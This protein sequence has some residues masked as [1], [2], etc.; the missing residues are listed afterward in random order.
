[1]RLVW[2]R[3]G[4]HTPK[5]HLVFQRLGW[6]FS[7]KKRNYQKSFIGKNKLSLKCPNLEGFLLTP[8]DEKVMYIWTWTEINS[9]EYMIS[10]CVLI[11]ERNSYIYIY[12][13]ISSWGICGPPGSRLPGLISKVITWQWRSTSHTGKWAQRIYGHLNCSSLKVN[14]DFS[15]ILRHVFNDPSPAGDGTFWFL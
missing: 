1:M 11:K 8:L 4:N 5:I 2:G 10:I 13:Y 6:D 9:S 15:W 7:N 3:Y 12:I 14:T